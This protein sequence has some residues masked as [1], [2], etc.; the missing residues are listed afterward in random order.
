LSLTLVS[1]VACRSVIKGF[2]DERT[3]AKIKVGLFMV[4]D[5]KTASHSNQ[6][7]RKTA[8]AS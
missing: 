6:M 1:V 3:L 2:L 7:S 4:S 8:E 5:L